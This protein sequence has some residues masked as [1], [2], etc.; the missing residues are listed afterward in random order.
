MGMIALLSHTALSSFGMP[1]GLHGGRDSPAVL[2][3]V[4]CCRVCDGDHGHVCV[5][6]SSEVAYGEGL[7]RGSSHCHAA[8][9]SEP[10]D[11]SITA[12]QLK[13]QPY[14]AKC[15]S[16]NLGHEAHAGLFGDG[17]EPGRRSHAFNCGVEM[18]VEYSCWLT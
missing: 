17:R 3:C 4:S 8:Q 10:F 2:Q 6:S 13:A 14:I 1:D 9:K 18:F 11:T 15:G 12:M 7:S 16:L 5:S